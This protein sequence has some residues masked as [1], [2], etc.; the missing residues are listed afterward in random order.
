[1][2]CL[3]KDEGGLGVINITAQKE[4][5]LLKHLH[6][7]FNHLDVPWVHLVWNCH[8]QNDGLPINNNKGSFWWRD[9]LKLCDLFR[10]IVE[11]K[12]GDGS[13]VL[14]WSDLWNDN[15]LQTKYP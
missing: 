13:T 1:M 7:F 11:C 15:I 5:L 4:S 12:I 6:K 8:Y 9:I 10:G 2:V 3:P 14:F